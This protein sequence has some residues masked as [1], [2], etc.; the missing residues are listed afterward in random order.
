VDSCAD[1]LCWTGLLGGRCRPCR[2]FRWKHD[3]GGCPLCGRQV[4][5][6]AVG[7][8]RL[9]LTTSRATG[10]IPTLRTGI[11]LFLLVG[12]PARVPPPR[13]A[14]QPPSSP[15][16]APGLGQLRLP[17]ATVASAPA[18]PG[19]RPNQC[20]RPRLVNRVR[21]HQH[22]ELDAALVG[23]G[24]ARG[25][26]PETLR[27][28]R[29]SL[30]VLLANQPP[31]T[32]TS[33]LQATAVRQFL[34]DRH[35]T[36]LRLVEFLADQGLVT[37]NQHAILD[38]WLARR[39]EPLPVGL[40]AEVQTW[41]EV[42][43]GRG[44]RPGRPRKAATIQGYL[45][46]LQPALAGWSAR[47]QSLR[48][49]TSDD[50]TDQLQPLTGPTRLLVL[51]VMRSLFKTLKARRVLFTNPTAGLELHRQPPPPALSLDPAR[52]AGLL[53]Q[54]HRPD[55]RLVVLLAGVHALR[56]HQI[57][58]LSMDD[59]DLAAGTLLA[60]GRSRR[61]DAL[62][63]AELRAWL[64]LRRTRWP[65]SANPYLLVNQSTAG[66]L[67]PVTRGY[68]Q[69]VFQRLGLTA[70]Q[71]RVDR[72]LA[73]VQTTGGDPLTLT[74]L[75]GISDPTAIRYCFELDPLDQADEPLQH[76]EFA[77]LTITSLPERLQ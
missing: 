64:E 53:D 74:R 36:A 4:P 61:L 31:L 15:A 27:R 12:T 69:Q 38:R 47:Y 1:C 72:L 30:A 26:S 2:L 66:G 37:S 56:P 19:P 70:Q 3:L 67:T 10:T 60:G 59:V 54:L 13:P 5:L 52:R 18:R 65:T 41:T 55:R 29:G 32:S 51:A 34:I 11:Q 49:V 7:R 25:W 46:A 40:R 6:G 63:L 14:L 28:T 20:P 22:Q 76:G 68:V 39:L 21:D 62:T 58:T 73:E 45:R 77:E 50:I 33:P 8:C 16:A 35:L 23:Y 44:P 75:F 57:R 71:L 17:R 9:C 48:Q 42:L 43:R 24:Q